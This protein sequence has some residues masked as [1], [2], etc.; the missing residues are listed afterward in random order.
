MDND[1]STQPGHAPNGVS[2]AAP[3]YVVIPLDYF[4]RLVDIA[5]RLKYAPQPLPSATPPL[6]APTIDGRLRPTAA[7]IQP[8]IPMFGEPVPGAQWTPRGAAS[9]KP[10]EPQRT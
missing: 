2:L 3:G 6:A 10:P 1:G 9:D 5:A 4:L 7:P 8:M